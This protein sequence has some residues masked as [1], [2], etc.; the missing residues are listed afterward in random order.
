MADLFQYPFHVNPDGTVAKTPEGEEYYAQE[1][2]NLILTS[3]GERHLVPDYGITDPVF[4]NLNTVELL[5]KIEMFGPP[6]TIRE[7]D[8]ATTWQKEGVLNINIHYA[9]AD[10]DEDD[11]MINGLSNDDNDNFDDADDLDDTNDIDFFGFN[12]RTDF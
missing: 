9:Q 8:I 3:P 10:T 6:V 1:L 2:A 7:G 4:D 12:Q 11:D 5:G